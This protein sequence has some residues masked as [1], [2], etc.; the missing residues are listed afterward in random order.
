MSSDPTTKLENPT[1]KLETVPNPAP[2]RPYLV[3]SVCPEFT[4][5][6]PKT[7][8]PDFGTIVVEYQPAASLVELKS[9]KLYIWSYRDE[10]AYH[11][12]VTNRILGDLVEAAAPRWMRV[13]GFFRVRGGITTTVVA[14]T[15]AAPEGVPAMPVPPQAHE[16]AA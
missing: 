6:C 2:D 12:A 4:C 1:T 15:G 7:G 16:G 10:G 5:V 14:A 9:L 8:Q 3:R 13:S 11:E